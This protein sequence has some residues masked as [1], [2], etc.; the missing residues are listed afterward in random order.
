[1]Y[2]RVHFSGCEW[3]SDPFLELFL[4]ATCSNLE[5]TSRWDGVCKKCMRGDDGESG[6]RECGRAA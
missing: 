1:M 6:E 5:Q 2:V 4:W 3:G